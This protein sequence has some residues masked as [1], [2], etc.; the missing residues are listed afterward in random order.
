MNYRTFGRTGWRVSDIGYGMW[1]MGSWSGSNDEESLESLQRSVDLG[2]NFFDT[3]YV[4]GNGRS[5]NLLGKLVRANKN[6][7]LE[8]FVT[9]KNI[10]NPNLC[11][12]S[13]P[14]LHPRL[15]YTAI[16]QLDRNSEEWAQLTK[17]YIEMKLHAN[18]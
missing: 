12:L 10:S 14:Y 1:G 5:E 13:S 6:K 8:M 17:N 4:Y 3:A 15:V 7:K 11:L 2:C 9:Q 18:I 16:K